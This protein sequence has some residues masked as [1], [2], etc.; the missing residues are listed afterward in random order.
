MVLELERVGEP[1]GARLSEALDDAVVLEERSDVPC[2]ERML[3]P[4]VAPHRLEVDER[5]GPHWR[6]WGCVEGEHSF[7]RFECKETGVESTRAHHI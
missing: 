7:H 6:H 4:C 3:A 2:F 5:F 1:H